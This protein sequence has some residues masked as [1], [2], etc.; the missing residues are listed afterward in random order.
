MNPFEDQTVPTEGGA[1]APS[2]PSAPAGSRTGRRRRRRSGGRGRRRRS[3]AAPAGVQPAQTADLGATPNL[4]GAAEPVGP[5]DEQLYTG[6]LDEGRP[7]ADDGNRDADAGL[8]GSEAGPN[9]TDAAGRTAAD[10][11]PAPDG[12]RKKR[13]RHRGGRR[14]RRRG[15]RPDAT[16]TVPAQTAPAG[17]TIAGTADRPAPTADRPVPTAP[18]VLESEIRPLPLRPAQRRPAP[19]RTAVPHGAERAAAPVAPP[20][21]ADEG[22]GGE[23]TDIARLSVRNGEDSARVLRAPGV[24]AG[25][26]KRLVVQFLQDTRTRTGLSR[27]VLELNGEIESAVAAGLAA[28]ALGAGQVHFLFFDDGTPRSREAQTRAAQI[29]QR[30]RRPLETK[31]L[32]P[33][34]EAFFAGRSGVT[35]ERRAQRSAWERSAWLRD[36][37]QQLGAFVIGT[38][39]K[40]SRLLAPEA[41][42]VLAGGACEPLGDLYVSQV[43]ELARS[44]NLAAGL[45]ERRAA[46]PAWGDLGIGPQELDGL[47]YQITDLRVSLARLVELGVSEEKVRSVYRRLRDAALRRQTP[48]VAEA[49]S[50][51]VPRAWVS[52]GL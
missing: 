39:T 33:L 14:H 28:E 50:V 23:V 35:P 48:P 52:D 32:R 21:P 20:V 45:P 29:A 42:E 8:S 22:S 15:P 37:A 13:R 9:G 4:D 46:P 26:A 30:W 25:R 38:A 51:T 11:A 17:A 19:V 27:A 7:G 36:Q 24:E 18:P 49:G 43:Q 2:A 10:N 12:V 44:L 41:E 34:V 16:G 47:L 31:D 6:D 3:G 5:L 1:D 40:T